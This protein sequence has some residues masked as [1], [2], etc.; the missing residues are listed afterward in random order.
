MLPATC[1][2]ALSQGLV[3]SS[4]WDESHLL[5]NL[6]SKVLLEHS[7]AHLHI[8]NSSFRAAVAELIR[9]DRDCVVR[10]A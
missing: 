2:S 1:A 6:V 5:P 3:T 8:I 4:L 7:H 10:K 9:R